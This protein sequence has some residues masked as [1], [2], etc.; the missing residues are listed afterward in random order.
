[1]SLSSYPNAFTLPLDVNNLLT[2]NR[3]LAIHLSASLSTHQLSK[4]Q[5]VTSYLPI[6]FSEK[7][8]ITTEN[9]LSA[10]KVCIISPPPPLRYT[11]EKQNLIGTHLAV[12]DAEGN[13]V[14]EWK[15]PVLSFSRSAG[16]IVQVKF[17]RGGGEAE[18]MEM[19]RLVEG[20]DGEYKEREYVHSV[21]AAHL[22]PRHAESFVK[23]G[24]AFLWEAEQDTKHQKALFKVVHDG[25]GKTRKREV[26]RFAQQ[27]AHEKEGLLVFDSREVDELVVVLTICAMLEAKDSFLE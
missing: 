20:R 5:D 17:P 10:H 16:E 21:P 13:E 24:I 22:R 18:L 19:R 14:A 6:L 26:A 2:P 1:M 4:I 3:A 7:H 9:L 11:L 25:H 15:H 27:S 8:G 12:L 23:D